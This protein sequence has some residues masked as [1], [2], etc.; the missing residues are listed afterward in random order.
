MGMTIE[1]IGLTKRNGS[2]RLREKKDEAHTYC[3][4]PSIL[5]HRTPPPAKK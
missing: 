5:P 4:S 3:D 2:S 1:P